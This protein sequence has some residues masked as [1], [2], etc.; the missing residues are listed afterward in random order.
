MLQPVCVAHTEKGIAPAGQLFTTLF[1]SQGQ[2]QRGPSSETSPGYS[3]EGSQEGAQ[4]STEEQQ[5]AGTGGQQPSSSS[6]DGDTVQQPEKQGGREAP[7]TQD[8]DSMDEQ[9]AVAHQQGM[10]PP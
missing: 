3:A 2:Q 4:A 8:E 5:M 9:W 1:G 10:Y 6:K 7:P